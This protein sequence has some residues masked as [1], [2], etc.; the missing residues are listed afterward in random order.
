MAFL[1]PIFD[2]NN[3]AHFKSGQNRLE[4]NQLALIV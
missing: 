3:D 2:T 4:N 1:K